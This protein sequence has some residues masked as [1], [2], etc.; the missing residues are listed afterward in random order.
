MKTSLILILLSI[1]FYSCAQDFKLTDSGPGW[2]LEYK[3]QA[4]SHAE[5]KEDSLKSIIIYQDLRIGVLNSMIDRMK[6]DSIAQQLIIDTL[7]QEAQNTFDLNKGTLHSIAKFMHKFSTVADS[8]A[9]V[10]DSTHV[11]IRNINFIA[12]PDSIFVIK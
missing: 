1:S 5:T 6:S 7:N 9:T 10:I 8:F 3:T 4:F 12:S 2:V 11:P